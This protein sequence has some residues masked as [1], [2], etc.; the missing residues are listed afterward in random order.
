MEV[1]RKCKQE[2]WARN[3]WVWDRRGERGELQARRC[4]IRL[5]HDS[6]A[7][8]GIHVNVNVKIVHRRFIRLP[9][10]SETN[11]VACLS[12][13]QIQGITDQ[14]RD[15]TKINRQYLLHRPQTKISACWAKPTRRHV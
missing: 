1:R 13:H 4:A 7:V 15:T 3:C 11:R 14:A 8:F 9:I 10:G 2:F 12:S 5:S 6:D